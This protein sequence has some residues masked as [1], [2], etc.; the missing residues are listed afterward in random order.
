MKLKDFLRIADVSVIDFA[1]EI[2][3]S[4]SYIYQ[5]IRD[6]RVVSRDVTDKIDALTLGLV[7][8]APY[9][10]QEIEVNMSVKEKIEKAVSEIKKQKND[11]RKLALYKS[12]CT[13][14]V[15]S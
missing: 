8:H 5:M 2:G 7:E 1:D 15:I 12:D 14:C 6:D 4:N 3:V 11:S 13:C 9:V 10:M